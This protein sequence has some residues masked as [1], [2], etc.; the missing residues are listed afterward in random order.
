MLP[1]ISVTIP[2]V[3]APDSSPDLVC[4]KSENLI[5]ISSPLSFALIFANVCV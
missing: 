2:K 1:L 3:F 5:V 4:T